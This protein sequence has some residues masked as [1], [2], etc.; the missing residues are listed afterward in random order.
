[1]F[2]ALAALLLSIGPFHEQAWFGLSCKDLGDEIVI[3]IRTET[4]T[5]MCPLKLEA[6]QVLAPRGNGPGILEL[7]VITDPNGICL[8]AFGPHQG[9]F[10]FSKGS[11][12]LVSGDY[13]VWVNGI[14]SGLLYCQDEGSSLVGGFE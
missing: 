9:A 5:A 1:M 12:V 14:Y 13:E 7:Q 2:L 6:W 4:R 10:H 3:G 8:W 11:D